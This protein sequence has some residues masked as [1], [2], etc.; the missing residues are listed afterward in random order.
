MQF[1][2]T[3]SV[4]DLLTPETLLTNANIAFSRD[5]Y[6]GLEMRI[7]TAIRF[8]FMYTTPYDYVDIFMAR[9]P[10]FPKMRQALPIFIEFANIQGQS[11]DYTSEELFYGAVLAICE[12][13]GLIFSEFQRQVF[14]GLTDCW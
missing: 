5:S 8:R 4:S 1:N 7:L 9:F 6:F 12:C 3:R 13:G 2:E 14:M 11:C 10:F